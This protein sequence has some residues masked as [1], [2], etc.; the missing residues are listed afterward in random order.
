MSEN[1]LFI[2]IPTY[3]RPAALKVQLQKLA[4]QVER[5]ST[6]V[7]VL[8]SDNCSDTYSIE[9]IESDFR[10]FKTISFRKNGGNIGG[11]ANIALGFI[12]SRP[13]EFLWILSDND[14]VCDDAVDYILHI[15]D[16][17]IDFYCFNDAIDQPKVVPHEWREGWQLPMDWRM[18][19]I[20]DALYNVKTVAGSMDDAFYYHNSSFPH[21]AVACSA[22]KKKGVV[23]FML[24][25]RGRISAATHSSDE[26][27]TDY[28]LAQVCMPFLAALFPRDKAKQFVIAWL[29]RHWWDMY[30]NRLRRYDLYLQ[31]KAITGHYGGW[32]AKI[33]ISVGFLLYLALFPLSW[34]K[35]KMIKIVKDKM[36]PQAVEALKKLRF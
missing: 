3:N 22:A 25:P 8:V 11:N 30:S 32:F 28:S 35:Q 23:N 27:P 6:S 19:L 12:F 10:Q 9:E 34:I 18:G 16:E 2:Y 4:L 33:I 14:I 36:S 7:R 26:C 15:L 1:K 13:G 29:R 17:K 31:S 24:L 20:S 5:N 21:L